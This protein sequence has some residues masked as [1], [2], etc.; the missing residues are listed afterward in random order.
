VIYQVS[1]C[2]EEQRY[3]SKLLAGMTPSQ[4]EGSLLEEKGCPTHLRHK[5]EKLVSLGR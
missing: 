5:I 3:W 4:K 2:C 1:P